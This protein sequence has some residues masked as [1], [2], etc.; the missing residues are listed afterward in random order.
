MGVGQP[1]AV[2]PAAAI[3]EIDG[4]PEDE[5]CS[6][7]TEYCPSDHGSA[8]AVE[9]EDR[10]TPV[11]LSDEEFSI[12]CPRH[13]RRVWNI[14]HLPHVEIHFG[15]AARNVNNWR[16]LQ[17]VERE[18]LV[19]DG[20]RDRPLECQHT[21]VCPRSH[22]AICRCLVFVE[23]EAEHGDV[24]ELH[25]PCCTG[26]GIVNADQVRLGE[27]PQLERHDPVAANSQPPVHPRHSPVFVF[28]VDVDS[29]AVAVDVPNAEREMVVFTDGDKQAEMLV[30]VGNDGRDSHA[31]SNDQRLAGKGD[32]NR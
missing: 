25:G 20:W 14:R 19:R 7:R 23:K 26:H 21:G 10:H 6:D 4:D 13:R 22:D 9:P 31:A 11:D 12:R 28:V 27:Q 30:A 16:N 24:S 3:A 29:L 5:T 17:D 8:P 2:V 32:A 18:D 1:Y 15:G